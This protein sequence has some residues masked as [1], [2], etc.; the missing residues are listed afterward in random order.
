MEWRTSNQSG[1]PLSMGDT[2]RLTGKGSVTSLYS[3]A[4][5]LLQALRTRH[6]I[7]AAPY[8][9]QARATYPGGLSEL[10][11]ALH[12]L[13]LPNEDLEMG[14]GTIFVEGAGETPT[15]P[16]PTNAVYDGAKLTPPYTVLC[17]ASPRKPTWC[18]ALP[19]ATHAPR[20]SAHPRLSPPPS[21]GPEVPTKEG[22]S[23]GKSARAVPCSSSPSRPAETRSG[24]WGSPAP[25]SAGQPPCPTPPLPAPQARGGVDAFLRNQE[26]TTVTGVHL[27]RLPAA[28]PYDP[29][30]PRAL[31]PNP[32]WVLLHG[33][34]A[35]W[36]ACLTPQCR[37]M[38]TGP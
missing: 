32:D 21:P 34:W 9:N 25:T 31:S 14:K 1:R 18:P 35:E 33:E 22:R 24:S 10:E 8:L 15:C 28:T 20:S 5:A 29:R 4:P 36:L 38:A 7:D 6:S 37:W 17:K 12:L 27:V 13:H 2:L 16:H 26:V 19:P 11:A 3:S 23:Y 30:R